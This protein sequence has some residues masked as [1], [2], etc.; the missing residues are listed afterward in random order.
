MSILYLNFK[1][2]SEDISEEDISEVLHRLFEYEIKENLNDDISTARAE[3]D[4]NETSDSSPVEE[5]NLISMYD[6]YF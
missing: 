6:Y 2:D 1:E 3:T 4:A 5:G